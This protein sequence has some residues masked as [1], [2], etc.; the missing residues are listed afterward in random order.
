MTSNA[1][2]FIL[3]SFVIGMIFATVIHLT[4][5]VNESYVPMTGFLTGSFVV[6]TMI[7]WYNIDSVDRRAAF[8][9]HSLW[10][11]LAWVVI[12]SPL[13]FARGSK[14]HAIIEASLLYAVIALIYIMSMVVW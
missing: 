2:N 10:G 1:V 7:I 11:G 8:I 13:A 6:G 12:L 3:N 14:T 4:N 5:T 9:K